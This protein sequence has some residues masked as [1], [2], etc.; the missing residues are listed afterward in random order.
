MVM[1]PWV[2]AMVMLPWVVAMVT[3]DPLEGVKFVPQ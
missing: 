2:V 1:L 3:Q